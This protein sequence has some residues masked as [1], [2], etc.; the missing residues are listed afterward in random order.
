MNLKPLFPA[1]CLAL[2]TTAG[3][4]AAGWKNIGIADPAR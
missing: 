4:M 2:A 3:L 1:A